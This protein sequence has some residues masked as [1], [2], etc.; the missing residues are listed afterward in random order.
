[1]K[2]M[3]FAVGLIAAGVT[4]ASAQY[5]PYAPGLYPYAPRYHNVCQDKARRLYAYERRAAAD[6]RLTNRERR[7]IRNLQIDLDRTCGRYRWRG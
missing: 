3:I 7:I 2:A 5:S 6:R 1:M 4:T